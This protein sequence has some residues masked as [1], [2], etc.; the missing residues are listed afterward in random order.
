M[1]NNDDDDDDD[2][3]DYMPCLDVDDDSSVVA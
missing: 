3:D 1:P 2:D